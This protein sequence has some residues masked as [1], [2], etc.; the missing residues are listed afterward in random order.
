MVYNRLRES[1]EIQTIQTDLFFKWTN[2]LSGREFRRSR[3]RASLALA[4]H[5]ICSL[6]LHRAIRGSQGVL[7]CTGWG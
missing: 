1:L 6:H 5:A 4:S 7:P 2:T 3:V